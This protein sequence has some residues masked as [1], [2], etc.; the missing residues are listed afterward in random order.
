MSGCIQPALSAVRKAGRVKLNRLYDNTLVLAM[1]ILMIKTTM[2]NQAANI[3][4]GGRINKL[5]GVKKEE[6]LHTTDIFY[7]ENYAPPGLDILGCGAGMQSTALALMSC[8]NAMRGIVHKEVPIYDAILFCDLGSE[9][10]WVYSQVRFIQDACREAKIPFYVIQTNLYQDFMANFGQKRVVSIPFWT[11]GQDGKRGRM[12]RNCTM[13][14]KIFPM[15]KF[16]RWNLLGYKKG[17]RTRPEDLL[18]RHKMHIGFSYEERRR[19]S[20]SRNPMF[21]NSFP[22]VDM[23]L[24]RSD[25]YAYCRNVWDLETRASACSFCPYHTN[26][27]FMRLKQEDPDTY[28]E[29]IEVDGLLQREQKKTKIQSELYISKSRKR[30]IHLDECDC[31][32]AEMFSCQNLLVCNG[33]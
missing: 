19:C 23:K 30:I 9:P 16:A 13:D 22:L 25:N 11:I 27:F 21:R 12:P 2:Q 28:K 10:I 29:L 7:L 8:E 6:N 18:G 20:E 33:F 15:Q 3:T 32:D 31:D 14:Y 1:G 5:V 24:T 26:Y 17:Q 4:V